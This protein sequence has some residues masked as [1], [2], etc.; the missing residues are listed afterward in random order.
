MVEAINQGTCTGCGKS[1]DNYSV[2]EREHNVPDDDDEH[3]NA[4]ISRT[5]SCDCG[6]TA[7]VEIGPDGMTA[8]GSISHENATWVDSEPTGE[9]PDG[10]VDVATGETEVHDAN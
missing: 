10:T 8:A 9:D 1:D 2:R 4:T 6:E 5:L 7:T 3:D